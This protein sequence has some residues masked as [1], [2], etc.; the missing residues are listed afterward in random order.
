MVKI[1]L[2]PNTFDV[3]VLKHLK[4]FGIYIKKTRADARHRSLF[5]SATAWAVA[6]VTPPLCRHPE[7]SYVTFYLLCSFTSSELRT[8]ARGFTSRHRWCDWKTSGN[9]QKLFQHKDQSFR[10]ETSKV[11]VVITYLQ[12]QMLHFDGYSQETFLRPCL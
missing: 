7:L 3:N 12:L 9:Q 5:T 6:V 10:L 11:L 2:N 8:P 4:P 1:Y